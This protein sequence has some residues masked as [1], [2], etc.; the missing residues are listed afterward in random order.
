MRARLTARFHALVLEA[1]QV[2]KCVRSWNVEPLSSSTAPS[3]AEKNRG[4]RSGN[5]PNTHKSQ[6]YQ[7][8]VLHYA[9]CSSGV[10]CF[11]MDLHREYNKVMTKARTW[12]RRPDRAILDTQM[13]CTGYV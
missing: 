7:S 4:R 11:K 2:C 13:R 3:T 10:I 12:T 8:G 5:T 6:M 1:Y 9:C